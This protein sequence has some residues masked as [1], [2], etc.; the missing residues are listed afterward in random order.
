VP[1]SRR[2]QFALQL[3]QVFF[4]G[5]TV[6]MTRVVVPA[7]AESEY[8]LRRAD[9]PLLATF[10]IAFGAVKAVMNL[11]AGRLSERL[12]RKP[13]L[14][15]GWLV[16]LPIPWLIAYGPTWNWIIAAVLLLGVNQGL[17][18]SMTIT[19]KHDLVDPHRHGLAGGLN[20]F[21][22][23][24]AVAIAGLVT[25]RLASALG[26]RPA[27]LYFGLTVTLAALLTAALFIRE[28]RPAR[29]DDTPH[30]FWPIAALVSLRDRHFLAACQAGLVEKFADALMWILPALLIN[31]SFTLDQIALISAAYGASWGSLQLLTGPLSDRIGRTTPIVSGMLLCAAAIAAMPLRESLAWWCTT[32]A[33]AGIGMS[34]LYP[35]LGAAVA[36]RADPAW[37]GTALGIYR[38]WRDLGYAIGAAALGLAAHQGL[39]FRGLFSAVAAALALSGIAYALLT[40]KRESQAPR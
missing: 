2:A 37:R 10:I 11:L 9:L 29:H 1:R 34:L 15:L 19:A 38:F 24:L 28:S 13:V 17:T 14:I 12:G 16:A 23:Y 4:V 39:A 18:W 8:G 40:I 30:D 21:F 31:R 22:G 36:H 3:L 27:L 26:P 20:E 7:V 25:A 32:A 33:A 35:T 6:G 5:L